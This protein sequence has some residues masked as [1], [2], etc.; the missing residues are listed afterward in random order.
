MA[1]TSFSWIA[2]WLIAGSSSLF[3]LT[4]QG[5][6]LGPLVYAMVIGTMMLWIEFRRAT[7]PADV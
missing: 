4:W 5:L 1:A 3:G 7:A 6:V 2:A